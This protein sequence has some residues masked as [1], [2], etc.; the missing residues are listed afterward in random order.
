MNAPTVFKTKK[1]QA[2]DFLLKE[3]KEGGY[4]AGS[5]FIS[6]N[7]LLEKLNLSRNTLREALM[8]FV[9]DGYLTR[10]QGKGT[11]VTGK[12]FRN[13]DNSSKTLIL[14]A[15]NPHQKG[16]ADP[17]IGTIL[18]GVHAALDDSGWNIRIM[19]SNPSGSDFPELCKKIAD[20]GLAEAIVIAGI[21]VNREPIDI[22]KEKN[23]RSV[24]IGQ[25]E[26]EG[27]DYV[28]SDNFQGMY[29]TVSFLI[30]MGHRRIALIDR[31]SHR[32]SFESRR[33]GYMNALLQGDLSV[34]PGLILEYKG[35]SAPEGEAA[36]VEMLSRNKDFTAAVVYGDWPSFGFL[37]ELERRTLKVPENISLVS[38]SSFSWLS[39]ACGMEVA[40]VGN[41]VQELGLFA[42]RIASGAAD[43]SSLPRRLPLSLF[44]GKSIR[45]LK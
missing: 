36:A 8:S 26:N 1:E 44:P 28:D 24:C 32:K 6:E 38:F 14:I 43:A 18:N 5:K 11:F 45:K 3:L 42:A 25:P 21:D 41:P 4:S 17:F 33:N 30:N 7:E 12:I 16:E 15:N 2:F 29:D 34:D 31:C 40:Q 19:Y 20:E 39:Q 22:L 35:W 37:R 27:I 13:E 23:I 9:S 10:I